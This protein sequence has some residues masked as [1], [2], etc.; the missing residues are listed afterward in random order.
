MNNTKK[1][2][3]AQKVLAYAKELGFE[4]AF[5]TY[6]DEEGCL[7]ETVDDVA[8]DNLNSDDDMIVGIHLILDEEL[9]FRVEVDEEG[10]SAQI[11]FP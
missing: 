1:V 7:F 3:A 8:N 10:E 4:D 5:I 11:V 2:D 9:T 6:C